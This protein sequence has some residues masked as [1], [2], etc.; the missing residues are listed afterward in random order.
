[1]TIYAIINELTNASEVKDSN[2]PIWTLVSNNSILQGGNPYFVPDF[3][4]TFELRPALA[5]KI[6]K[7]GK[8]IPARFA[9]RYISGVAPCSI[10]LATDLL[11]RLKAAEL[12]W[13]QA[14]S[15]DRS[16]TFGL[17]S[18]IS[19]EKIPNCS[20]D[21]QLESAENL[22]SLKWTAECMPCRIEEIIECL[23]RDNTLKTG[24]IIIAGVAKSGIML[25]PG[26]RAT[27]TL[28]GVK[29]PGFNIR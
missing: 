20:I 23:S 16:T 2:A 10:M 24:D 12:P 14:L 15:Y 1:M 18:E 19:A 4:N 7:L 8:G 26:M 3:A 5:I 13:T 27:M 28:D 29:S 9:H 21:I 11:E 17:F 25:Y 6:G 22:L